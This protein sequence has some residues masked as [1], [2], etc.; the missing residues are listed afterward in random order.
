MLIVACNK[1]VK[2]VSRTYFLMRT[3]QE[4]RRCPFCKKDADCVIYDAVPKDRPSVIRK[5]RTDK[6]LRRRA[7][8]SD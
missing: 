6:E 8:Y 7:R 4:Y 2:E 3:S 5:R 1:C